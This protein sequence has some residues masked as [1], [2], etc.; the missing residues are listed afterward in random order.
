MKVRVSGNVNHDV[1]PF[2]ENMDLASEESKSPKNIPM[3]LTASFAFSNLLVRGIRKTKNFLH[4]VPHPS[5]P[6]FL[7]LFLFWDRESGMAGC[8]SMC[9][10]RPWTSDPH[11]CISE[12]LRFQGDIITTSFNARLRIEP[13]SWI[14]LSKHSASSATSLVL[15]RG[16]FLNVL[17]DSKPYLQCHNKSAS[18]DTEESL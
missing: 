6:D 18:V 2:N 10:S 12:V 9:P 13:W 8:P 1:L 7:V 3:A 15:R 16:N 14:M 11:V 17:P 4:R 5:T